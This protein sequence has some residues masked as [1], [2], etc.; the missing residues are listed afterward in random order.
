M[1]S[2]NEPVDG[3]N[4]NHQLRQPPPPPPPDSSGSA[5]L[6]IPGLLRVLTAVKKGDFTVRMPEDR[7][8]TAGKVAD[9]LNDI[10]ELNDR[11]ANE[12]AR[13]GTAVGKE[14]RINQR[15]SLQGAVGSWAACFESVNTLI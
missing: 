15:G 3:G 9:A 4:N 8:G 11:M 2:T 14:G 10:I 5:P 12:F 6:D 1:P 13:I 7:T